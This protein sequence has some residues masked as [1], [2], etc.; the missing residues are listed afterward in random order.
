MSGWD[1]T[2]R[3]TLAEPW[4]T[5]WVE[6][7]EDPPMGDWMDAR[8]ATTKALAELT[9][10][11][12]DNAMKAFSRLLAG[13]N[14]TAR[15]GEPIALDQPGAFRSLPA[16]LFKALYGAIN[17]A[18]DGAGVPPPS[19]RRER[20]RGRSSPGTRSRHATSSGA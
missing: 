3:V 14:L 11:N 5:F 16:S 15:S 10:E 17:R 7:W 18:L 8:D 6:L 9:P 4:E 20:S 12:V 1:Q 2:R 13:H 19:A